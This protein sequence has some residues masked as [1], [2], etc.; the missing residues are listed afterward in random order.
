MIQ[1]GNEAQ[2]GGCVIIK[3]QLQFGPKPVRAERNPPT[4][5]ALA[6]QILDDVFSV[7][8]V[9]LVID[10]IDVN[11]RWLRLIASKT[12]KPVQH[13]C[14]SLLAEQCCIPRGAIEV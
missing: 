8:T 10:Q 14:L 13:G 11:F 1:I 3:A 12:S 2:T 9:V 6:F 5:N 7:G 4:K